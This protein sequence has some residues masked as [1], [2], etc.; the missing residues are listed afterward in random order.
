[1][2]T[3]PSFSDLKLEAFQ[4][5]ATLQDAQ[6]LDMIHAILLNASI[7]DD[8]Y[9]QMSD[10]DKAAIKQGREELA[11]GDVVAHEDITM[12]MKAWTKR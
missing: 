10:E 5:L 4:M 12:D 3:A 7:P 8:W 11:A 9:E 1:M 6:I 2:K